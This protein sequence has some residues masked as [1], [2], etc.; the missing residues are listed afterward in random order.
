MIVWRVG[1]EQAAT[2]RD[3]RLEAL[4]LAPE[5]FDSTHA[6]WSA[7]PLA[8]FE[9]RLIVAPTFVAGDTPDHMLAT[10][11]WMADLDPHD[12]RRAWLISV[13]C[14]PA[15]RGRGHAQAAIAAVMTDAQAKGMRSIG[16][17]VVRGNAH[18]FALYA[19]LGFRD[20]G[21][22]GVTNAHGTPEIEM[23]RDLDG[24]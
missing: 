9:A 23:M 22:T 5:V 13:Y 19:R 10:A 15:G 21:R 24:A 1:P 2:W 20:T 7:R 16:L 6:D 3:L 4:R 12:A 14:R 18:A 8:D 17:N 11:S